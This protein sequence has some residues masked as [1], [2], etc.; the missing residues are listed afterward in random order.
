ML[1]HYEGLVLV[2]RGLAR[3]GVR[4]RTKVLYGIGSVLGLHIL[5][6]WIFG[7]AYWLL[8][9]I[10]DSG[11]VGPGPLQ[12]LDAVYFSVVTFTTVGYGDLAPVGPIRLLAGTEALTGFVLIAWSASFTY[13]E[14]EQFW[15]NR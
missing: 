12:L 14:M 5:E 1:L 13:L 11:M 4:R 9:Q 7:L 8:L 15:R 6:V 3:L 2:S 10:P